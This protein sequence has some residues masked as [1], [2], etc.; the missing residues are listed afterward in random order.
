MHCEHCALLTKSK[1]NVDKREIMLRSGPFM[2]SAACILDERY[3]DRPSIDP[4]TDL[5]APLGGK[6]NFSAKPT[7][8]SQH[9]P[10]DR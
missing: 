3:E 5:F 4:L 6:A 10:T 2:Q 1:L 9:A 7:K 8:S